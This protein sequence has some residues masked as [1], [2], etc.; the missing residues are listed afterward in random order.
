MFDEKALDTVDLSVK[1]DNLYLEE[2]FTDL[3]M[4]SIRRLTPV[5]ANGLKDKGRKQIFIGHLNLMTPQGPIPVQ[6]SI[7]ARNLKEAMDKY[8]EAMKSALGKMEEEIK[9]L[10]QKQ[11]SR[12]IVPGS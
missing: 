9:K 11:D 3:D 5:K 1:Q 12:I 8:P 4:A 10:Q 2:S 6:A 7:E